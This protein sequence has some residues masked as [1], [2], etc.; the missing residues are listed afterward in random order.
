MNFNKLTFGNIL[1]SANDCYTH[2]RR[3][4]G[5]EINYFSIYTE[6]DGPLTK[7]LGAAI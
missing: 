4:R 5:Y 2:I 6:I 1:S 3:I 7:I